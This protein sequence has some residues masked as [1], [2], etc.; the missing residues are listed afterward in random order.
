[1][2]APVNIYFASSNPGKLAEFRALAASAVGA[3]SSTSFSVEMLPGFESLPP[4]EESA[5]TFGENALGKAVYYSQLSDGI[6]FAD[7]SG[8]VVPAL[9]GAPGVQSARYAGPDASSAD[10]ISKLLQ[11]LGG[12]PHDKRSAYFCCVIAMVRQGQPIAVI[13]NRADGEILEV[14]RGTGGF[15]YD[16]IFYVPELGKTFAELT[17]EEKNV[18]SHRGKAFRRMLSF[19]TN[20]N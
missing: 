16:P 9:G 1:M 10:R 12:T 18:H 20:R 13:S 2:P 14:P 11:E 8:L 3:P 17:P 15:G 6:V 4:F 19:L 7:D 5:P